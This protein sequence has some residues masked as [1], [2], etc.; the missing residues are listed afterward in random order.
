MGNG[1]ENW[2]STLVL[3]G[4][5]CGPVVQ[6]AQRANDVSAWRLVVDDGRVVEQH[7]LMGARDVE[8]EGTICKYYPMPAIADLLVDEQACRFVDAIG[9]RGENRELP[10]GKELAR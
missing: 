5:I 4:V 3:T 1:T 10:E 9:M 7:T 8:A 2:L 6:V